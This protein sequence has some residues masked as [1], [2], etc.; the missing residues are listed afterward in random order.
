[1]TTTPERP[2]RHRLGE[3]GVGADQ[4]VDGAVGE[5]G[6]QAG[7]LPGGSAVGEQR[8][9]GGAGPASRVAGARQG[10][11]AQQVAHAGVVLLGQD[12]GRR[13][14]RALVAALDGREQGRHRHDGLA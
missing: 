1:M 3:Q 2:E 10:E 13:H 4:H 7:P 6:V 5:P 14:Q 8:R 9:P 12:L 11:A